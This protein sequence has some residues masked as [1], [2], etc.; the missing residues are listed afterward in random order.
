MQSGF[1]VCSP[2][3]ATLSWG[4]PRSRPS[5]WPTPPR[6]GA[7]RSGDLQDPRTPPRSGR[8]S[9]IQTMIWGSVG[10]HPHCVIAQHASCKECSVVLLSHNVPS[11]QGRRKG[12]RVYSELVYIRSLLVTACGARCNPGFPMLSRRS[13]VSEIS[14]RFGVSEIIM[15]KPKS[16][17]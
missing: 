6:S 1:P 17:K 15:Y 16:H 13:R 2:D 14:G 10:L 5:I 11:A 3:H 8:A 12:R 4:P 7:L 9:Q